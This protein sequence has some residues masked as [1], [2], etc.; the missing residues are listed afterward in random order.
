MYSRALS[1]DGYGYV[2]KGWTGVALHLRDKVTAVAQLLKGPTTWLRWTH[3]RNFMT[4]RHFRLLSFAVFSAFLIHPVQAGQIIEGTTSDALVTQSNLNS[5]AYETNQNL[6]VGSLWYGDIGSTV[7]SFPLPYLAPGQTIS[8]ASISFFLQSTNGSPSI[9]GQLYGL[10]RVSTTSALPLLADYYVGKNDTANSLL[11]ATFLTPSTAGNQAVTY[12]GSNLVSFVQKQYANA[13]FSG[14]DLTQSRF[15]FFRVS[16]D[17]SPSAG[18]MNYQL[19][20]SRNTVRTMHPTLSLTI[21]NGITATAGRLQFSFSLPTAATTSAGVYTTSGNLIRTLWNNVQYQAGTNYGAW[22]GKDD[23]GAA[24]A[25]GSNYQ[26]K[27]IYHNVQYVWEGTVGNTS[28]NESGTQVYRSF[29][30]MLDMAVGGGKAYYSVGYNEH[31]NPFCYFTL[32]APQVSTQMQAGISDVW[33]A[34][35]YVAADATKVYWAKGNGGYNGTDT[36]VI[37]ANNSDGS[38]YTFPKGTTP[39]GSNQSYTSCV[40]FDATANQPNPATGLAVQQSGNALFVSHASL[41]LVRVFDKV[42]GTSLG[43]FSVTS[44]QRLAT[45]ANGDVWVICGGTTPV[46]KR[47]TF[48]NGTATLKTTI[49]GLVSP[50][51]LGVSADDSTLL[52]ADGGSSEQIKAFNNS[53]GAT[54]WTYGLPGGLAA[55][56]S[57]LTSNNFDFEDSYTQQNYIAFQPDNTFWLGDCGNQRAVHFS[58]STGTPVYIE[59]IA[60]MRASYQATVDLTDPTRVFNSFTEYTVNY[61]LPVG[62]TNGSWTLARNWLPTLP[63]DSTHSYVGF[64]NGW[65]NVVTLPNGRTYGFLLNFTSGKMDLFELLANGKPRNTGFEFSNNPRMYEDGSLRF[66]VISTSNASYYSQPLTGVDAAGNPHWG[67]PSLLASTPLAATDPH[68]WDAYPART[69]VTATGKVVTFDAYSG[70]NGYHLAAANLGSTS[71]A[72]RS[73]PST[74]STYTGW[75]PQDGKFDDGNGVYYAGNL[76]MALD[77]NI[78]FGYHGENW[79]SGEASMWVNYYDNGL[80]V[81]VFGTPS[82]DSGGN[83]ATNG[84]AGNSFS[85][86]LVHAP[87]GKVYLYANDES[88]HGGSIRWRIDGWNGITELNA[89]STLGSTANLSPSTAGPTVVLTS[90]TTG[91]N[92]V[93]QPSV[94]MSADAASSGATITSVQFFDGNTNLGTSTVAPFNLLSTSMTTGSHTLTAKATDS[95]GASTTSAPVSIIL[96]G[97]GTSTAPPAPTSLTAGTVGSTGATLTWTQPMSATTSSTIGR[98]ISFQFDS[99]SNSNCLKPT[100]VAG[101]PPYA[102]DNFYLAGLGNSNGVVLINP[103]DSAGTTIPNLGMN[104]AIQGGLDGVSINTLTGTAQDIFFGEAITTVSGTAVGITI[105]NVPYANYDLVVYSLP[106]G[107]VAGATKNGSVT[108]TNGSNTSVVTQTFS[109]AQTGYTLSA[110]PVGTSESVTNSNTLVFQGLNGQQFEVQGGCIESIQIVERPYDQ[111]VPASYSIERAAG[112]S[113]SF[114]SIGTVSGTTLS[115]TDSSG[116]ASTTYQYRVKAINSFGSSAYS[117]VISVTTTA[118]GTGTTGTGTTGTGTT[119]TGTTGTGT[120][121]TGTTG[122]G[123]TGTGTTGTGTTG[124]GTTGTGTTGTGTT[125][126]GTTSTTA[127]G[128]GFAS[129]QAKYFT[130]AQLA[131]ASTSGPNADP[132]GSTVPNLVAYALQMDP[133]VAQPKDEPQM[134]LVGGHATMTYFVPSAI[135][136]A[137]YTVEVSSDLINWNSGTGY[138]TVTSTVTSS[139]G[140]TITVQDV[141]ATTNAAKRFMRLNVT[142]TQ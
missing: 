126:T 83:S 121:G 123:T 103:L 74:A 78:V 54:T 27:L 1:L 94:M 7:E 66:N 17:G 47:Y 95:N 49:T 138:T 88:N 129:W 134:V 2:S 118:S 71:W 59:Q 55:N 56:G 81:G 128:K 15:V 110:V 135:T 82:I 3:L 117:N 77:R 41:N 130:A 42:Q 38:F 97:D 73:S 96:S 30:E 85:P 87:N 112:T 25:T 131:D 8:G 101:A 116:S 60:Y 136:D 29:V 133:S 120:T 37:A 107:V 139:T 11:N 36:Y 5:G 18:S 40:D 86:T 93:N 76:A 119:G 31:Q 62:G 69:E 67:S 46:V 57:N 109:G 61:A 114:A 51:G 26:I 106:E 48:A 45:T 127:S 132:Y 108:V 20:C 6:Y 53:T 91:T 4:D 99:T 102:A 111:G 80:A 28:T 92:Y 35:L 100:D 44:P 89:T 84:Y 12:S 68:P 10:N 115:Y 52:V 14:Q 142:L 125:G 105:S 140:K 19:G 137:T 63:N 113:G 72:W 22:D 98:I 34:M 64:A 39:T 50:T 9:N 79:K 13:A 24:V 141:S 104:L 75:F 122:T 32:G 124:T 58:L 43:S 21:A 70:D 65:S 33:S 90:P 23:S 16:P